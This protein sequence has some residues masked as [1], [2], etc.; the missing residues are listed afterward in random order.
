MVFFSMTYG[1]Y[2]RRYEAVTSGYSVTALFLLGFHEDKTPRTPTLQPE[3]FPSGAS[4]R[5]PSRMPGAP[6]ALSGQGA[7]VHFSHL[8][9]HMNLS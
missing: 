2:L 7:E 3:Q 8:F 4:E 1:G 6:D 5:L 9:N